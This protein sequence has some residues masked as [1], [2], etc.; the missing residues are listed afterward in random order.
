M[1]TLYPDET[2]EKTQFRDKEKIYSWGNMKSSRKWARKTFFRQSSL[3]SS[4]KFQFQ[5]WRKEDGNNLKSSSLPVYKVVNSILVSSFVNTFKFDYNIFEFIKL[6]LSSH[7]RLWWAYSSTGL[8]N[9]I[10][11]YFH[12]FIFP[13]LNLLWKEKNLEI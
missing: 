5:T 6:F 1:H 10:I 2:R 4:G 11:I 13:P 8:D 12:L 3:Y 9:D 7:S